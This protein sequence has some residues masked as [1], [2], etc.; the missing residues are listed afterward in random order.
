MGVNGVAGKG[1]AGGERRFSD[2]TVFVGDLAIDETVV[3]STAAE[4]NILDGVTSTAAELNILDGVTATAS[5]L[6]NAADV[7]A[8]TQELT[9]TGS[10]T[11]GVQSVEL[12]SINSIV[13]TAASADNHQG[14]FVI[15]ATGHSDD[16]TFVF[17]SG[18]ID[19]TN[20]VALFEA[21]NDALVLYIDSNGDG[22]IV[23]NVGSVSLG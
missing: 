14:L 15:K 13:A 2:Q 10:V 21:D 1:R 22:T 19:G 16:H 11:A 5:E 9:S 17:T 20:S 3:T 12:N 7:S 8:R 6:N 23:E 4:L 18:T